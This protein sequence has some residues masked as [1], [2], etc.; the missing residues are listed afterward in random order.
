MTCLTVTPATAAEAIRE[1]AG[2][3]VSHHPV[4][5]REVKKI[6]ADLPETGLSLE[7]GPGRDRDRQPAHG[8]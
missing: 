7:A 8:V 2:L 6:R 3:I 4:L 1:R 5:F